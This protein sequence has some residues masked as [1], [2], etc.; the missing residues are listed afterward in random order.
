MKL[1]E[2]LKTASDPYPVYIKLLKQLNPIDYEHYEPVKWQYKDWRFMDANHHS[3]LVRAPG[4]SK[5]FDVVLWVVLQKI[6]HPEWKIA[7][8]ASQGGQLVQSRIYFETHPFVKE[9][10]QVQ[11]YDR[12]YLW[13]DSY[14]HFRNSSKSITGI[15]LDV[16]V[17]DEEEMLDPMQVE[18][19]YPQ[20][21]GRLTVST[22]DKFI[23]L[24]TMQTNTL[25]HEHTEDYP[26]RTRVWDKCPWLVKSGKIQRE[27]DAGVTP[28]HII[29]MLYYCVPATPGGAILP[30]LKKGEVPANVKGKCGTDHGNKDVAVITY[31][32]R[33]NNILYIVGEYERVLLDNHAAFDFLRDLVN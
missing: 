4:G 20:L 29:D 7:W 16:I 30:R 31:E 11:G 2:V 9:I 32:D 14:I 21:E 26:T 18:I 17:L 13:N 5:T 15:R 24:G 8:L 1:Q 6:L 12:I 3:C 33:V 25:F 23:H 28:K 10:R 19:V 22:I 27:I